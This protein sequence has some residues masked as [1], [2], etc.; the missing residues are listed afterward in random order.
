MIIPKL[1]EVYQSKKTK[2]CFYSLGYKRN[3]KKHA[4]SQY[5]ACLICVE[6]HIYSEIPL[7]WFNAIYEKI[8]EAEPLPELEVITFYRQQLLLDDSYNTPDYSY[9]L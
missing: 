7:S 1:G 2:H 3:D 9:Y 5:D 6:R 8:K 4:Q